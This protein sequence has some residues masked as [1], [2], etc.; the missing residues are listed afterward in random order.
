M[1]APKQLSGPN[2]EIPIT[3]RNLNGQSAPR[4]TR[5]GTSHGP[6][7]LLVVDGNDDSRTTLAAMLRHQGYEVTC[8]R[9][10]AEATDTLSEREFD[11]VLCSVSAR[12]KN[13]AAFT[14]LLTSQY[15][16]TAQVLLVESDSEFH[17]EQSERA[18]MSEF[19]ATPCNRGDLAVVVQRSLTRRLLERKH[20]QRYRM[21]TD[22]SSESMLDAL[23]TALNTRDTEAPGHAERVTAYTME[24]AD[25]MGI[26][27]AQ[28]YHIERGALLHDIGKIG[29]PDRILHKPAELTSD[30]WMEIKKHPVTGY[31][32]CVKI[33]LLRTAS[34]IV[35]RHHE[36]WDGTG[37]PD[38]L[39]SD[40][41]PLGARIFSVADTLDAMTSNR[42]Y[43]RA[44]SFTMARKEILKCSGKQF[45]PE[46]VK[47][48]IE[49]PETRWEFIRANAP[50]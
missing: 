48:F 40:A 7:S 33:D 19:I 1:N 6:A 24:I 23:L 42:P 35:L 21:A 5:L 34:Q 22:S 47:V 2:Y 4:P 26:P 50:R 18:G 44:V 36:R 49:V 29:I 8:S 38:G 27:S 14:E 12:T 25:R 46:I 15:P 10:A 43:R 20:A 45:D 11:L 31:H 30:E 13:G 17:F 41:I 32:M 16:D 28:M 37:Y 3:H 39:K 9:G